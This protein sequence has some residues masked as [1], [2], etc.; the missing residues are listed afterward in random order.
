[1]AIE[2]RHLRVGD[3]LEHVDGGTVELTRLESEGYV[4]WLRVIE[5]LTRYPWLAVGD[6]FSFPWCYRKDFDIA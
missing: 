4:M 2:P 5:P 6:H 1:M 3:R